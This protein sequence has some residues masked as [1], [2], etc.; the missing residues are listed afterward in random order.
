MIFSPYYGGAG[1]GYPIWEVPTLSQQILVFSRENLIAVDFFVFQLKFCNIS[2][3][4]YQMFRKIEKVKKRG[5][6][7]SLFVNWN[8][9]LVE[10][11]SVL[12]SHSSPLTLLF[13]PAL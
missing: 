8:L 9:Y 11:F 2:V 3:V 10:S 6:F 5:T 12:L 1:G 13:A 4:V 7:F